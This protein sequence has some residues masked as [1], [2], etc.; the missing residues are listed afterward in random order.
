MA[1]EVKRTKIPGP[2]GT[3]KTYRLI[4]GP[5]SYLRQELR[6]GTHPSKIAYLTFGKDPTLEV[7]RKLA[8]IVKEFPQYSNLEKSF[9]FF[10]TMHAMGRRRNKKFKGNTLLTGNEWN[11]FKNYICKSQGNQYFAKFPYEEKDPDK[12]DGVM[13]FGNQYLEAVN[14]ARCRKIKLRQQHKEM[15]ID[16][17][18]FSYAKLEIFNNHLI[19][20]KKDHGMFDFTDMIDL[21]KKD[22]I[23]NNLNLEVVFLDEAQDLNPL[24][25][26]MFFYIE[27][28]CKRSYIAGDDD[29]TIFKFQGAD[30]TPFINLKGTIDDKETTLSRRVPKKV[31]DQAKRIL[32][33][34]TTRM[35]KKWEPKGEEGDFIP[36]QLFH[37]LDYSKGQWFLLFRWKKGNEIVRQV[38]K[39]FYRN[40]IYFDKGNDL[41]PPKLVR[42]VTIWKKLNNKE[43]IRGEEITDIWN[44]MSGKKIKPKGENL[45]KLKKARNEQLTLEDLMAEY[46]ILSKG[47]WQDCF[48]L[49]KD[50]GQISYI[51]SVEKDLNPKEKARVR[52]R[53]IH[54]AKG[55]EAE[56]VVIFPDMPRPAW[57]SAK[58]DSDTEHRMWFVAVTRAK[59]KVYWLNPETKYYYR[60]GNR[61]IA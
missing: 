53:T 11:G 5:N 46:G 45:K 38:K 49:I 42:A 14:I 24:Q 31:F 15:L 37:N 33:C 13:T 21:F 55:D 25:W 20:Y 44:Y 61:R 32:N 48:D 39:Y 4:E 54:G 3:G 47:K 43:A 2:P 6:K 28:N 17:P 16:H 40:N 18:N 34:I 50:L 30:P 29:Q 59:Q 9:P 60:I 27:E 10:S 8:N 26:E 57:R 58:R 56:N 12:G 19:Q 7:Q 41:L 1:E 35:P 23:M 52:I 36:N 51:E 22:E